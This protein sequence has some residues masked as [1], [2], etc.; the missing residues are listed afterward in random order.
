MKILWWKKKPKV[1]KEEDSLRADRTRCST[2]RF[3]QPLMLK[4]A[5]T[6][7]SKPTHRRQHI[8]LF[9]P[10][11]WATTSLRITTLA[12][13]KFYFYWWPGTT[14]ISP[15]LI[16]KSTS[17]KAITSKTPTQTKT[18]KGFSRIQLTKDKPFGW[19][20]PGRTRTEAKAFTLPKLPTFTDWSKNRPTRTVKI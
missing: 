16:L 19:W 13:R 15:K 17:P 5:T 3:C 1:L 2:K 7:F 20:S 12:L 10:S 18:G 4:S 6:C 8:R 14:R 11:F 9:N